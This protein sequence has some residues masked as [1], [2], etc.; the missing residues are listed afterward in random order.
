MSNANNIE[1]I[2]QLIKS[3]SPTQI[4]DNN[5]TPNTLAFGNIYTCFGIE[6]HAGI[7]KALGYEALCM[8]IQTM[9]YRA[10]M[11]EQSKQTSNANENTYITP[12]IYILIADYMPPH[13]GERQNHSSLKIERKEHANQLITQIHKILTL[14]G[15]EEHAYPI[16]LSTFH[17]KYHDDYDTLYQRLSS[18]PISKE[19]KELSTKISEAYNKKSVANIPI[20]IP[21]NESVAQSLLAEKLNVVLKVGWKSPTITDEHFFDLIHS[22]L[23]KHHAVAPMQFT[24]SINGMEIQCI[25]PKK[26]NTKK[27]WLTS[28]ATQPVTMSARKNAPVSPYYVHPNLE[29]CNKRLMIADN[30]II[31]SLSEDAIMKDDNK[32]HTALQLYT[33]INKS[34]IESLQFLQSLGYISMPEN[35]P[36][37]EKSAKENNTLLIKQCLNTSMS[38]DQFTHADLELLSKQAAE[39][40]VQ[41]NSNQKDVLLHNHSSQTLELL[42]TSLNTVSQNNKQKKIT[43][44][45]PVS[46]TDSCK[47]SIPIVLEELNCYISDKN[48]I[49]TQDKTKQ[50][51]ILQCYTKL[52]YYINSLS[53]TSE[54]LSLDN[55]ILRKTYDALQHS[56]EESYEENFITRIHK[57]SLSTSCSPTLEEFNDRLLKKRPSLVPKNIAK[58]SKNNLMNAIDSLRNILHIAPNIENFD[59]INQNPPSQTK[60]KEDNNDILPSSQNE[61]STVTKLSINQDPPPI[62]KSEKHDNDISPSSHNESSTVTTL[63]N[64]QQSKLFTYPDP[65]NNTT[66]EKIKLTTSKILVISVFLILSIFGYIS[67]LG[68]IAMSILLSA[69]IYIAV[70]VLA[71][72]TSISTGITGYIV[73]DHCVNQSPLNQLQTSELSVFDPTIIKEEALTADTE[74]TLY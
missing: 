51:N 60:P 28:N 58:Y 56:L 65:E 29:K 35:S 16:K 17:E 59:S 26:K 57:R 3:L 53:H 9:L 21:I 6:S 30:T 32:I 54:L 46:V 38:N 37:L 41:T 62:T 11:I 69:Y 4:Q 8:I 48:N 50:A 18:E 22:Y 72:L 66:P 49:S 34:L 52:I 71:I 14:F 47:F 10:L 44:G 68:A 25:T 2:Q 19:I 1:K 63:S 15:I 55:E 43:K 45:T 5:T 27:K 70:A 39:I 12:N 73:I 64:N 67:T 24:Y 36:L 23:V 42:H 33:D 7:S 20:H 74:N 61:N 13:S 40:S 31:E